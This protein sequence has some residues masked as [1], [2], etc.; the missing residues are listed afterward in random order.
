MSQF[1][2]QSTR[3]TTIKSSL[4]LATVSAGLSVAM[5]DSANAYW[6]AFNH[7]SF[8]C[9]DLLDSGYKLAATPNF[10]RRGSN[11]NISD[12]ITCDSSNYHAT[13]RCDRQS[14]YGNFNVRYERGLYQAYSWSGGSIISNAK[15][16]VIDNGTTSCCVHVNFPYSYYPCDIPF[17]ANETIDTCESYVNHQRYCYA[18]QPTIDRPVKC[19]A[20]AHPHGQAFRLFLGGGLDDK[21]YARYECEPGYKFYPLLYQTYLFNDNQDAINS[22]CQKP[23]I[24]SSYITGAMFT[25]DESEIASP[26][27][28][29][30]GG[31]CICV[32]DLPNTSEYYY[33]EVSQTVARACQTAIAD[34]IDLENADFEKPFTGCERYSEYIQYCFEQCDSSNTL[35]KCTLDCWKKV[36]E[37]AM[38]TMASERGGRSGRSYFEE[39]LGGDNYCRMIKSFEQPK[40][41]CPLIGDNTSGVPTH[42]TIAFYAEDLH[43]GAIG[44]CAA[45][46][47]TPFMD[48][49]GSWQFSDTCPYTP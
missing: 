42:G 5:V 34:S 32:P 2:K 1:F 18:S 46:G 20:A 8:F 13:Y 22:Y 44:M 17:S 14:T 11:H 9:Q 47:Q 36:R 40:T 37:C 6:H 15:F 48:T 16:V 12:S 27:N 19:S 10:C 38:N 39:Y 3:K 43:I 4:I 26:S 21:T 49:T 41:R 35:G 7:D 23:V 33:P 31:T 45:P 25:L 24:P 29:Y 30:G 28:G